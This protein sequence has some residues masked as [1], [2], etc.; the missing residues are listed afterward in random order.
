MLAIVLAIVAV[1]LF[2]TV[3]PAAGAIAVI[4]GAAAAA[5]SFA[6]RR[7]VQGLEAQEDLADG[8]LTGDTIRSVTVPASFVPSIYAPGQR[9]GDTMA[10]AATQRGGA[11]LR[12]GGSKLL[13]Q[14][15]R[16]ALRSSPSPDCFV[17]RSAREN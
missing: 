2:A 10:N 9:D 5:A 15:S 11:E 17:R 3:G 13:R 16:C 4:V 12:V 14:S 6:V 1:V 7:W 8:T